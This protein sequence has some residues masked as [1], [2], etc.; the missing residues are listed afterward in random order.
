MMNSA[1]LGEVISISAMIRLYRTYTA[2]KVFPGPILTKI[3][4]CSDASTDASK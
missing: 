1:G 4:H 3:A 2:V